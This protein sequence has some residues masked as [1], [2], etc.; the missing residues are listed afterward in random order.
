M[1]A[2]IKALRQL[3]PARIVVAVPTASPKTCEE[4]RSEVDEVIGTITP[5]PFRAVGLWYEDFSQTTDEEVRDLLARLQHPEERQTAQHNR[6]R[7][8]RGSTPQRPPADG[9]RAGLCPPMALIG[10]ARFVLLGRADVPKS[11]GRT[12]RTW[13]IR[14]QRRWASAAR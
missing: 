12:I 1:H 9:R 2:A 10:G 6:H 3:Q 4:L 5:E 11:S 7:T 8:Y 13:E 14:G